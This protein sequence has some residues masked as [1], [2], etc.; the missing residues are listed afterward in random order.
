L[1]FNPLFAL[2]ILFLECVTLCFGTARRMGGSSSS[3]EDKPGR[4]VYHGAVPAEAAMMRMAEE[5]TADRVDC[6][7]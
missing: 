7:G 3:S 5:A 4:K 6:L 1:F 2:L